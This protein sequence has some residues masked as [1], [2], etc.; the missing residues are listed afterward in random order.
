[1]NDIFVV[2]IIPLHERN[3]TGE[4]KE[5]KTSVRHGLRKLTKALKGV[6]ASSMRG[7]TSS[8]SVLL[9]LRLIVIVWFPLTLIGTAKCFPWFMLAKKKKIQGRLSDLLS[10]NTDMF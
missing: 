5:G 7:H 2:Y 10:H 8:H 1:L 6:R 4:I 9:T 3:R